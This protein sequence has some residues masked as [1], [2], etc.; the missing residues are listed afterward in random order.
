MEELNAT[1]ER[2]QQNNNQLIGL[3][4]FAHSLCLFFSF[5][6]AEAP[7][8]ARCTMPNQEQYMAL[9]NYNANE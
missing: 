1:C 5:N 7:L 6:Y 2:Q 9:L 4:R 8:L 3:Y